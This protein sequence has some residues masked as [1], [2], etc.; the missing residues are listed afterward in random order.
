MHTLL[1]RN[2]AAAHLNS[3][4]PHLVLHYDSC[5]GVVNYIPSRC[6]PAQE[7]AQHE[8]HDGRRDMPQPVSPQQSR[9]HAAPSPIVRRPSVDAG[10]LK[11]LP[12]RR[13]SSKFGNMMRKLIPRK[14]ERHHASLPSDIFRPPPPQSYPGGMSPGRK[15]R[16]TRPTSTPERQDPPQSPLSSHP[17]AIAGSG[18]AVAR[19]TQFV[20]Q[21]QSSEVARG[22]SLP[23]FILSASVAGQTWYDNRDTSQG[24]EQVEQASSN[25]SSQQSL[26][27]S[28]HRSRSVSALSDSTRPSERHVL[29]KQKSS[30]SLRPSKEGSRGRNNTT[31]DVPDIPLY[32]S[33][34]SQE[35]PERVVSELPADIPDIPDAP[36][37]LPQLLPEAR[38]KTSG[39]DPQNEPRQ[40]FDFSSLA[41]AMRNQ[42]EVNLQTHEER[43]IAMEVKMMNLEYAISKVQ[44]RL[45]QDRP[46]SYR[47]PST[48]T[49]A[50]A[51]AAYA[52]QQPETLLVRKKSPP[53]RLRSEAGQSY[54]PLSQSTTSST[55]TIRPTR[56]A[57][58]APHQ[59]PPPPPA[60]QDSVPEDDEDE[61]TSPDIVV[62]TTDPKTSTRRTSIT[63]LTVDHYSKLINLLRHEQVARKQLADEVHSLQAEIT[64]LRPLAH[65]PLGASY[66]SWRDAK[67]QTIEK[68][69]AVVEEFR[70]GKPVGRPGSVES[71]RGVYVDS[72]WGQEERE[73][74]EGQEVRP[75]P[76]V[77]DVSSDA[78]FTNTYATPAEVIH[79]ESVHGDGNIFYSD[80]PAGQAF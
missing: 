22:A 33:A 38:P 19:I 1:A 2:A 15:S 7:E 17:M 13:Q 25:A 29:R 9:R 39:K 68:G 28:R 73:D 44:G 34:S 36:H 61:P 8:P 67:S 59:R 35:A 6:P 69:W 64:A 79:G 37:P 65:S 30:R 75:S 40:T 50:A 11:S 76:R 62:D 41:N 10:I 54:E 56:P 16:G 72:S 57:P 48:D 24:S 53:P 63:L 80:V 49:A 3:S 26:A 58:P 55:S 20:N 21:K 32:R 43:L 31:P 70:A 47:Q 52:P 4:L 60:Q 46:V 51:E 74:M 14:S 23:N 12:A 18:D 27:S 78:G 5:S 71:E 77:S 45:P 66:R 42:D